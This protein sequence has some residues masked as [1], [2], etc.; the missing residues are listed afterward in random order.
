[1]IAS[2]GSLA[3]KNTVPLLL[4]GYTNIVGA[5]ATGKTTIAKLILA[6][7]ALHPEKNLRIT[8]VVGD[9]MSALHLADEF[10]RLFCQPGEKP[11]AVALIGRSTRDIHLQSLY[12]SSKFR[13]D[14]WALRWLNTACPLQALATDQPT[15]PVI[16]G[17]E[18]CE[19][20]YK[21]P[22]K[23]S[24]RKTYYYCPL[25]AVCPVKQQYRDMPTARIWITTP[26]AL[27]ASSIPAQI[28]QRKV[29]LTELVY[30]QSDLVIF[31]EA[32]TV[33]EWFDN[34]FAGEV[35]LT[36]QSNGN[37]LLDVEDVE[38]A[39]AWVTQRI[40]PAP[41]RR[42]LNAERTCLAA[43]ANIL[44]NLTDTE[45]GPLLRRWIGRN[46]FTSLTLAYKLVWRLLNLP[47]WDSE[48]YQQ[49]DQVEANKKVQRIV[50]YFDQLSLLDAL[51]MERPKGNV[52]RNP[53]YRLALIMRTLIS[54][55]DSG[56]NAAVTNECKAWILDFIPN[57]KQTLE[58][59][60]QQ[61]ATWLEQT[62]KKNSPPQPPPDDLNTF[63][64]RLEFVLSV[65]ILDRN[66]PV[67]FYEWYN[68]PDNVVTDLNEH[69]LERFPRDLMNVL[70]VPPTGR[71]FGTYYSKDLEIGQ[72]EQTNGSAPT[73]LSVFGYPNVG[74]WYT[75][76][77]H[78][79]FTDLDGKSGPNVLALSGTSWLPHSSRWH[80][81]IPPQGILDP[82]PEAEQ[83]IAQS[84]FFYCPQYISK[85]N[86]QEPIRISGKTQKL[87]PIKDMMRA[88]ASNQSRQGGPSLKGELEWLRELGQQKPEYWRDRER[89]LLIVNSYDQAKWAFDELRQN[90]QWQSAP[91]GEIRYL[92]RTEAGTEEVRTDETVYR[93][94]I[95]DFAQTN[96]KILIAPLQSIGRG[97]NI[98]NRDGKAAFGS[99]YFLTRPMPY[100]ADTQS[101]AR[102]LNRRTLD[103]CKDPQLKAWQEPELIGKALQLRREASEYWRRAELRSFYR[104]LK[105]KDEKGN[106]TYS[107]RFDL[108]ATTA[109]HII[110]ACGRLL[111]G[112]VPFHAYFLDA[113]WGPKSALDRN[114]KEASDTSL[115]TAMIEVLQEYIRTDI[116]QA[117]Y[118]S[119]VKA[120]QDI[121]GFKPEC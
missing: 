25:F 112:G 52:Q 71:M 37:G 28:E 91:P 93:G 33:Q 10:N 97:Y 31:D 23:L 20:L 108:A 18:P 42:W 79:L 47:D 64:Q 76:Y 81:D 86:T 54:A 87:T 15:N 88:L 41:T 27:G 116:G 105:H 40:Q 96:G 95:E 35:V 92:A 102:E 62:S 77:F 111:R 39:Q 46:F 90:D 66:I 61:K 72:S 32:D 29:H 51:T 89:L 119:I 19:S 118:K 106:T 45:Q 69:S 26:G 101:L 36:N 114:V 50:R 38:T 65:M 121:Q 115:L 103:W 83:A 58:K 14:H 98:L 80:I 117:L 5:V 109:G 2:D 100:P 94:D 21:L 17:N 34:L 9:T 104:N 12:R 60:A 24:Q 30:E 63:A 22:A 13:S 16:P 44:S 4:N 55:G 48:E 57:I 68:K 3:N 74:R 1:A 67:V 85:K 53:L 110:Q 113:A 8:L 7:A 59:L 107:E 78:N 84:K 73:G 99:I 70:P 56:H 43:I 82:S 11:V 49:L 120:I 75:M 6:D